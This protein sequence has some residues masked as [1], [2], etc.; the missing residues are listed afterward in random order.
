[1]PGTIKVLIGPNGFGKTTYL[2][3]LKK[4]LIS[5]GVDEHNILYLQSEIKL[6]D[7]VKDTVDTSQTMEYLLTELIETDEYLKKREEMYDAANRAINDCVDDLNAIVDGVLGL[8]GSTRSKSFISLSPKRNVKNLVSIDQSDIKSK[9]G[10]GQRMQLLLSFARKSKKQ[11]I[12]LDE[13]E[14]YSHPSLLNGTAQAINELVAAGKDV[15][16]ATHSPKL[17]SML[18]LDYDDILII[19][20]ASHVARQIPFDDAV[21]NAKSVVNLGA[22][23]KENK[24]YYQSGKSLKDCLSR[25]HG[26]QFIES[27][28]TKRVYLCEGANDELFV[29]EC[30]R[31]FGGYYDD[32]CI[33]KAWGKSNLPV[34]IALYRLLGI[35]LVVLFDIDDERNTENTKLN[36]AIRSFAGSSVKL[37]EFVPNLEKELGFT[38]EKK[39]A[40][41][42]MDYIESQKLDSRFNLCGDTL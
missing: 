16:I 13:P 21:D 27:L 1:M 9:M 42:F 32:Y 11:H 30:L 28:F 7:E 2:E 40:L 29:N 38:G 23:D 25:R 14:K 5:R 15:A 37:I 39:K 36:A 17:V 3:H 19:N 26:R 31:Q 41:A 20:D 33:V 34:F 35:D 24:R 18:E 22:F 4:D 12:I 6:L 8:N 10:S